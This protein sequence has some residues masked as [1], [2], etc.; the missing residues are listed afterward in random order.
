METSSSLEFDGVQF[1]CIHVL[2]LTQEHCC[3]CEQAQELLRSL[4]YEY[5]LSIATLDMGSPLG[6]RLAVKGGL[7]LPP[8]MLI[9]G[10]PFS[11]GRLSE[12]KLRRELDCRLHGLH[13]LSSVP[14]P[15]HDLRA[16]IS[17]LPF[18]NNA[19]I[20]REEDVP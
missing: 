17:A 11:Y 13:R 1:Q 18:V 2:L 14:S 10:K 15:L 3:F 6:W 7:L 19:W 9:D 20:I 4:S 5:W 8:G 12:G 16:E